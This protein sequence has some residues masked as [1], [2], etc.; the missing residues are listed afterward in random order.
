MNPCTFCRIIA[1]EITAARLA[2]NDQAIAFLDIQPVNA[3]HALIIPRRH[4]ASFVELTEEE[5][6]SIF[7]L[8]QDVGRA[9]KAVLPGCAGLSLSAADGEAAGQEVLHAHFHVIPRSEGDGF[10]WRRFGQRVDHA[11]LETVASVIRSS[12]S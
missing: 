6:A 10:G 1:G 3:G 4:V 2:E 11:S 8:V 5:G 9:M 12:M 7:R